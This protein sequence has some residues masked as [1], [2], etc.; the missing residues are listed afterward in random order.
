[1]LRFSKLAKSYLSYVFALR[2]CSLFTLV[3]VVNMEK[4]ADGAHGSRYLLELE[5]KDSNGQPLR[6]SRYIY[7]RRKPTLIGHSHSHQPANQSVLCNPVGLK[8]N[9]EAMVHI[10]VA[11]T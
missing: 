3:R 10:I 6:L 5:V 4:H 8:W 2:S 9:P 11:G 1:M 7:T